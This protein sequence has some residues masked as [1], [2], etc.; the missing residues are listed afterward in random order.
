MLALLAGGCSVD[1]A[2]RE[3]LYRQQQA[4]TF[5]AEYQ[6]ARLRGDL[7]GMCVKGNLTAA[8]YAD[9]KDPD[10]A[11]AWRAR[12][13]EDCRVARDALVPADH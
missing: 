3:H 11:A 8:A 4:R 10:D 5:V 2:A 6:Q 7:L 1:V 12:S 13:A 9:A